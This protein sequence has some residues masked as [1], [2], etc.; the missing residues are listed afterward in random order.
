M[1]LFKG[2]TRAEPITEAFQNTAPPSHCNMHRRYSFKQ[3]DRL[4]NWTEHLSSRRWPR[5]ITSRVPTPENKLCPIN[6]QNTT[7]HSQIRHLTDSQPN[8]IRL[9]II[10]VGPTPTITPRKRNRQI[11]LIT[12]TTTPWPKIQ[13]DRYQE[14]NWIYPCVPFT[15]INSIFPLSTTM[16]RNVIEQHTRKWNRTL[17][18]ELS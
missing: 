16:H 5:H 9:R 12:P 10:L 6:R 14:Q 15:C 3:Q 17:T 2:V 18:L 8:N 4:A 13:L 1:I 11:S 7:K